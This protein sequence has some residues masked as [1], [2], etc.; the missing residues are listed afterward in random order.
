MSDSENDESVFSF[1]NQHQ[2]IRTGLFEEESSYYS[3]EKRTLNK[4][5]SVARFNPEKNKFVKVEFFETPL[6]PNRFIRNAVTGAI[7]SPFRV[8]SCDED[9]Y[10]SVM[11][12]TGEHGQ[13]PPCLFYDT[14]EQY[15][16]HF[17][18]TVSD[19]AKLRWRTRYAN[20]VHSRNKQSAKTNEILVK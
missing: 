18:T 5:K 15:E 2:N 20:A 1:E 14:P 8:G 6:T 7:E 13:T 16:R 4:P 19:E 10:Y 17:F 11:L 9:L 3:D 12:S